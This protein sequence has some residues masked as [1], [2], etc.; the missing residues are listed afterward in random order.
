MPAGLL[1]RERYSV[2]I[3][4]RASQRTIAD[5]AGLC[6]RLGKDTFMGLCRIPLEELDRLILPRDIADLVVTGPTGPRIVRAMQTGS[7]PESVDRGSRLAPVPPPLAP[8]K[9]HKRSGR[10][11]K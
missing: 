2:V 7:E 8:A 6:D 1:R 5:M 4:P 3:G 11:G 9:G 10:P